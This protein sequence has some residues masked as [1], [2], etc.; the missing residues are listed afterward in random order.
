MAD[1]SI[2]GLRQ[3]SVGHE[4]VG[5]AITAKLDPAGGGHPSGVANP[6]VA[7]A[8]QALTDGEL[9]LPPHQPVE[10]P[11]VEL[12][13]L[14]SRGPVH[15]DINGKTNKG[16]P[17]GPFDV[18]KLPTRETH[19]LAN[20]PILWSHDN[21]QETTMAVLPC[22]QGTVRPG[23]GDKAYQIWEGYVNKNNEPIAGAGR[24]HINGDFRLNSQSLGACLTPEPA[25]GGTAWPSF[26]PTPTNAADEP[27]WEKALALW[28]NT[29]PGLIARWWVSSRQH[30]GRARLTVSTIGNIHVLDLRQIPHTKI[31]NLAAL[32][33]KYHAETLLP[34]NEAFHDNTR[35]ELDRAVLHEVL[36][37][38]ETI[39]GPLATLRLQWCAEPSVLG[40]K[41]TGPLNA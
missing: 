26:A 5:W 32:C 15:R 36:G 31:K 24:L 38:P 30:E 3:L 23:M 27:L 40:G 7:Q 17:R 29:T 37:L 8:A 35:T 21:Q 39:L 10:L 33:D 19:A 20:W 12:R 6:A 34:A 25:I 41:Q 11:V 1:T 2:S 13:H 28:L 4:S 22:S 18:E 16:D 9:D 14:G